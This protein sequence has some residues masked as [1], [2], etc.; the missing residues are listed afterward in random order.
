MTTRTLVD[1]AVAAFGWVADEE[2]IDSV[3][4]H[5]S[6]KMAGFRRE[7]FPGF[8]RRRIKISFSFK[9]FL[10]NLRITWWNVYLQLLTAGNIHLGIMPIQATKIQ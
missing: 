8:L 2:N 4:V 9:R 10:L 1:H 7:I 3:T 6:G 5:G